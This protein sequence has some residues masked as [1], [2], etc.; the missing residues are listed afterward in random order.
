MK[1]TIDGIQYDVD[2]MTGE[3]TA[4]DAPGFAIE[5]EESAKWVLQRIIHVDT[6]LA[7]VAAEKK[8]LIDNLGVLESR[9][10]RRKEGLE[11][12]FT[13]ELARFAR[14]NLDKGKKSWVCAFGSVSFRT[15]P[16]RLKVSD[17][18]KAL[19]WGLAN[20]PAS[21]KTVQEF[22][23]SKLKE[24]FKTRFMEDSPTSRAAAGLDLAPEQE[25]VQIKTGV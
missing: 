14:E 7:A 8:A 4:A 18:E 24:E 3:I 9:L 22:Q 10:L 5:D 13:D 6:Q 20:D 16:A 12:R 1:E 23:I 17:P 21:V 19:A 25:T 11:H 15:N 2:E